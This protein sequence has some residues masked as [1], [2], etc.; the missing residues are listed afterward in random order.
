MGGGSPI[1]C[2][3]WGFAVITY[4]GYSDT[5]ASGLH[6]QSQYFGLTSDWV[7]LASYEV[8]D[9]HDITLNSPRSSH[10]CEAS[11]RRWISWR[12]GS[13]VGE[14][15]VVMSPIIGGVS[16]PSVQTITA[17]LPTFILLLPDYTHN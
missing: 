7:G 16:H 3:L 10:K 12:V 13:G 8:A 6:Y 2:V 4:E 9:L 11:V 14:S 17:R 15:I 5:S 1:L